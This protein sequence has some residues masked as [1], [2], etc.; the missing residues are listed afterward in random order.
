MSQIKNPEQYPEMSYLK[1]VF[2]NTMIYREFSFGRYSKLRT[3]QNIN[4]PNKILHNEGINLG[5]MLNR[6]RRD[7][8]VKKSIL[9]YLDFL[10]EG[11][12]DYDICVEG[13]SLQV[14][15]QEEEKVIP[16]VRLSDG[17]LRFLY[18]LS[19]LCHPTPPPLVCIEHPELGI[20][21]DVLPIIGDLLKEAS[22]KCQLIITTHS[23]VLIHSLMDYP[24]SIIMC[25]KDE[26]GTQLTH[27]SFEAVDIWLRNIISRNY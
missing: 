11:I 20:H 12:E 13:G 10:Y 2:E 22:K 6:F 3:P 23:N 27:M 9:Q 25:E 15:L 18:L 24:D 14:I 5:L 7:P 8:A 4:F 16:A 26:N 21:P 19:I 1:D 17:T